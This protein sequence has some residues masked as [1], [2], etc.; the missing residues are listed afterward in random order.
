MVEHTKDLELASP[1]SSLSLAG[2]A[3]SRNSRW[4]V[5]LLALSNVVTLAVRFSAALRT[6]PVPTSVV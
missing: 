3:S 1:G 5:A 2:G 6:P 4:A